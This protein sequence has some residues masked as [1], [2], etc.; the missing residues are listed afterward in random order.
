M[1]RIRKELAF[2]LVIS[3]VFLW[4]T[5]NIG[6]WFL[7]NEKTKKNIEDID[8]LVNIQYISTCDDCNSDSNS[9][10]NDYLNVDFS[11]LLKENNE[12]VGWIKVDGTNINYPILKHNDNSYY[13]NHSFDKTSN[14]A[15]WIFMDYRNNLFND[16]NTII[17]GHGRVDGTMF[18][19]LKNTISN[20]YLN[21]NN[22]FVK[23]ASLDNSYIYEVFSVYRIAETDD[24]I[25]TNFDNKNDYMRFLNILKN[26]SLNNYNVEVNSDDKIITL[27]TCYNSRER[28]VLHAK[29][30]YNMKD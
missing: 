10:S 13:L 5:I 20:E 4:S 27:S 28:L 17:Y 16:Y 19:T 26:R 2:I 7:D 14:N 8:D 11:N 9:S 18:G 15:G 24:Y 22:K 1:K 12:V 21:S 6:L 30:I 23:I 25:K 29:L 3:L